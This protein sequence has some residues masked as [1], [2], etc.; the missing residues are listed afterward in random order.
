MPRLP[1][2]A[3]APPWTRGPAQPARRWLVLRWLPCLSCLLAAWLSLGLPRL[4][5]AHEWPW[6]SAW[7]A[8]PQSIPQGPRVPA[9]RKAPALRDQTMR[10][11]LVPELSG[12]SLRV[13]ISNRWGDQPLRIGAAGVAAA[14]AD[15]SIEPGRAPHGAQG[16]GVPAPA[17]LRFAGKP[18]VVIAPHAERWSDPLPW[19]VRAGRPLAISLYLPQA[20]VPTTWHR[21]AGRVQFIS[22]PGNHVGDPRGAAFPRRITSYLWVDRV[23]VLPSRPAAAL[24]AI[25]DSITDG[26]RST[27]NAQRSWPEQVGT[28]LRAR[29][30]QDLAVVDAGISGGRLLSDSACWG[31]PLL[32]RFDRDALSLASARAVV[33]LIG[34]NDIDFAHTPRLRGLD[35]DAPHLRVDAAMLEQGLAT[36]ARDAHA[37]GLRAYVGTLTPA[38][39]AGADEALRGRLNAWIRS[40]RDFDGVLDFDAALRDPQDPARMLPRLDSGDHLHPSDAGYA[41]MA[42]VALPLALDEAAALGSAAPAGAAAR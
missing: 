26:M 8:A 18:Q 7:E 20:T 10:L 31:P 35:C 11:V 28:L 37:R 23:D 41:A 29:G 15:G 24:V 39:L 38:H 19:P 12:S 3:A 1:Q 2:P 36:L 27:L 40:Q 33:V 17:A 5:C 30:V 16:A 22:G 32:Q 6:V 42:A 9:F 34:I 25:G 14:S 21:W 13:R 4:A